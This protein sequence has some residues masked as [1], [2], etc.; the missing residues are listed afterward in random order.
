VRQLPTRT[1]ERAKTRYVKGVLLLESVGWRLCTFR[2]L[3][4]WRETVLLAC[5]LYEMRFD[6]V[7]L[8]AF[9]IALLDSVDA[10]IVF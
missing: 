8:L 3:V 2:R 7:H 4:V 6:L 1:Y 9:A 10:Q 5:R